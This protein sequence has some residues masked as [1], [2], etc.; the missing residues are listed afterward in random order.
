MTKITYGSTGL[1]AVTPSTQNAHLLNATPSVK[2]GP[3]AVVSLAS[4]TV[5]A[6]C[7]GGTA[8]DSDSDSLVQTPPEPPGPGVDAAAA[9]RFLGQAAFGGDL[10]AITRVQEL[11]FSAWLDEQL[12]MPLTLPSRVDYIKTTF[13]RWQESGFLSKW[14]LDKS[15]WAAL[16]QSPDV[17][18]Q[19]V[20]LALSEIFVVS[21]MSITPLWRAFLSAS[22]VDLLQKHA[23]D[24]YRELLGAVTLSPAMGT[25]LNMNRNRKANLK[26][27][28]VPDENYAR[29]VLQLFSIGLYE[30]NSDGTLRFKDGAAQLT[31]TQKDISGLAAVFTGWALNST[32]K[33]DPTNAMK[34]MVLNPAAHTQTAKNFLT[35]TIPSKTDGEESLRIALDAIANHANVGPF[36]GKQLIQRL[37]TSN[38]S[39]AY[40]GRVAAVFNDNGSGVRGDLKAVVKA[41]LL[42]HEAWKTEQ[43]GE[44][45]R[46]KVREPIVRMVQWARTF[47]AG[48]QWPD[49][50]EFNTSDPATML[51][52]SPMRS[53]SVFNFFR[54]GYVPPSKPLSDLGLQAPELQITDETSVVGWVNFAEKLVQGGVE[55]IQPDYT[56]EL[57]LAA[58]PEVLLEHLS[59]LL[60]GGRLS[61]KTKTTITQAIHTMP[62]ATAKDKLNRV[63]AAVHLVLCVPEYLIQV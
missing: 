62:S 37:V 5:L 16:I 55:N 19:R 7:G 26:T 13:P 53:P 28:R 31:Y 49:Q 34:P 24:T 56:H 8:S 18:R 44:T 32:F 10:K 48:I 12:A 43:A 23:F 63:C 3:L 52:Q 27:G 58:T 36:I 25:M 11:G 20:T 33:G 54:P 51:G 47:N 45:T 4:T 50:F 39:P 9:S 40:V 30:L 14:R 1:D 46:G 61:E 59:L 15:V 21:M 42:D 29:E 41:V 2:L 17:L 35:T 57:T 60:A 22:Y 38:P 6:A